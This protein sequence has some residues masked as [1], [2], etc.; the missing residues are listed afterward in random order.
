MRLLP[1]LGGYIELPLFTK[2]PTRY[3]HRRGIR[4]VI[5]EKHV[6]EDKRRGRR[7]WPPTFCRATY[8]RRK[9][10]ERLVGWLKEHRP[11]ATRFEKLASS[12]LAMVKLSL[13]APF[14][15]SAKYRYLQVIYMWAMLESNQRPPP[16]K[17]GQHFPGGY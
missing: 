16:C 14:S 7:G 13:P 15:V 12:F 11:L 4:C 3:L 2:V 8:R 5:P 17:L 9:A 6:P 10:V 1:S